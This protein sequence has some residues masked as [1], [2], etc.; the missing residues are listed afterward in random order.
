MC[1]RLGHLEPL[2]RLLLLTLAASLL[3]NAASAV[4]LSPGDLI[5]ADQGGSSGPQARLL[6]VNPVT[7]AQTTIAEGTGGFGEWLWRP[8][9]VEVESTG[10]ILVLDVGFGFADAN[11]ILRIEPTT[12]AQSLV[13]Q[14]GPAPPDGPPSTWVV[15]FTADGDGK[16]FAVYLRNP[17]GCPTTGPCGIP[18]IVEIDPDT[19][20]QSAVTSAG[21][22]QNPQAI[23][24][25]SSGNLIVADGDWSVGAR[26]IRVSPAGIQTLI[27][28]GGRLL[29][30]LDVVIDVNG[31]YLVLDYGEGPEGAEWP[32]DWQIVRVHPTTGAQTQVAGSAV[33]NDIAVDENGTIFGVEETDGEVSRVHPITGALVPVSSGLTTPRAIAVVREGII[34]ASG[35]LA[36]LVDELK[37]LVFRRPTSSN[38]NPPPYVT[39]QPWQLDAFRALATSVASGL[40]PQAASEADALGYDLVIFTDTSD[41]KVYRVLREQG[42]SLGW[43]SY[44][45]DPTGRDVLIEAPH[46]LNDSNT[47]ELAIEV[48]DGADAKGYLLA[49][50]HRRNRGG[51]TTD[52]TSQPS[53]VAGR[54]NSVFHV[55]HEAWS[56]PDT[57]PA[58]IHGYAAR[59]HPELPAG[60]DAVLSNGC[61]T[62]SP[63]VRCEIPGQGA[64]DDGRVPS[65]F[66]LLDTAFDDGSP[67][68]L[69]FAWNKL[70]TNDAVNQAVNTNWKN[71]N[72]VLPGGTFV[73]LSA[74]YNVQLHHT[75]QQRPVGI[76]HPA[77][78]AEF[79]RSVRFDDPAAPG[80]KWT[81]A[82]EALIATIT[83][84]YIVPL[85]E[86]L[87][88]VPNDGD[89]SGTEGD[90]PCTAGATEDCDDNCPLHPNPGQE[91]ADGDG[92][93]NLCDNCPNA[94]NPD[95]ADADLDAVGDLCDN[96]EYRANLGQQDANGDG[97]GDV[98]QCAD[99]NGDG[100]VNGADLTLYKRYFG[101]LQSPFSIDRC[102]ASPAPD[103]GA[104]NGADLTI[105]KR[106]F[107]GL[108]PGITNTCAAYVGP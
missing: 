86:D 3:A 55:V 103:G 25:D 73:E 85:D 89:G 69:S 50:A 58:Q 106:Y 11:A 78:H 49:G 9:Q 29:E 51:S 105:I 4:D 26:V 101:G 56:G 88:D 59:N 108:P 8:H 20:A 83:A 79:E 22:M 6:R 102:G 98:C 91:D 90:A 84:I 53:N 18:W 36:D 67:G 28:E 47:P 93:G 31:D 62:W 39:P 92:V 27:S 21:Y 37:S 64:S 54:E 30:P 97:L 19:G 14:F 71:G 15:D 99:M 60:T 52:P 38:P 46:P 44:I 77:I 66:R 61:R 76:A 42:Q 95:R 35:T 94:S 70:P 1:H 82:V 33:L 43:G 2:F 10:Q 63:S 87:D 45:Y 24:A 74:N 41:G 75:R 81:R 23:A 100:F 34:H 17:D 7:G 48:Y 80:N 65:I 107:G 96:C 68:L 104:C 57:L 72:Q 5:V 12:G 40:L 13:T 16:I 32:L